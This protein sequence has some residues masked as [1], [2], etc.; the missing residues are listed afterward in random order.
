LGQY[1]NVHMAGKKKRPRPKKAKTRR[2]VGRPKKKF[3][4]AQKNEILRRYLAGVPILHICASLKTSAVQFYR[5][6]RDDPEFLKAKKEAEGTRLM[7]VED[8]AYQMAS[9]TFRMRRGFAPPDK[10]TNI[11][12]L[13]NWAPTKYRD[14][15]EI[16]IDATDTVANLFSRLA[17]AEAKGQA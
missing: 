16:N 15:H 3:T 12:L 14:K 10:T 6:L 1:Q 5:L 13:K 4:G 7:V 17:S 2:R 8:T 11:F 9:G